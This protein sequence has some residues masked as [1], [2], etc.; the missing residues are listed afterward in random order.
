MAAIGKPDKTRPVSTRHRWQPWSLAAALAMSACPSALLAADPSTEPNETPSLEL[1]EFL[2]AWETEDGQ[3]Q[4]PLQLLAEMESEPQA[5]KP[6]GG[7]D[8]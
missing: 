1:L 3:W 6:E 2:G 7:S 4:D 5:K 8:E